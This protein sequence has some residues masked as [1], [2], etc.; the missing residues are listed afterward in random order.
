MENYGAVNHRFWTGGT[1]RR[2]R[3]DK[4]GLE[5]Q[6]VGCYLITCAHRNALG[7]YYLPG[8][9]IS[10]ETALD[11]EGASKG[12]Q[13]LLEGGFCSY[14]EASETVWVHEMARYQIGE[15]IKPGDN[16]VKWINRL[17]DGLHDNPYLAEFFDKYG[18]AFHIER[19][20]RPKG[21]QSPFKA[22]PKPDTDT[23][24]VTDT[25]TGSGTGAGTGYSAGPDAL[26]LASLLFDLISER[27]PGHKKPDLHKWAR[28]INLMICRDKRPPDRTEYLNRLKKRVAACVSGSAPP[29]RGPDI[30]HMEEP[31]GA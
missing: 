16:R 22:P 13:S 23:D 10:H 30:N 20:R 4:N 9:L 17:Y 27:N 28:D 15:R 18:E 7:L 26:R 2:L 11:E 6:L 5:A 21:L 25:V 1:G 31:K 8:I 3:T 29:L 12:L 14:D 24:T 19:P